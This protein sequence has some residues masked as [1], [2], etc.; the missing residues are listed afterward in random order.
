MKTLICSIIFAAAVTLSSAGFAQTN[1]RSVTTQTQDEKTQLFIQSLDT[2]K[3]DVTVQKPENENVRIQLLDSQGIQLASKMISKKN[4][5]S[6]TRF[7]L[8]AL[9]DGVYKI[10]IGDGSTRQV[11]DVILDTHDADSYRTVTNG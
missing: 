2:G 11:K 4:A 3:V 5:I 10:V 6:R 9:P 7:D 1:S 8:N